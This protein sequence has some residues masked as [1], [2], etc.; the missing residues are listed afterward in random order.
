MGMPVCCGGP[1][2]SSV[3][4]RGGSVPCFR[5]IGEGAR[6]RPLPGD[7][8]T[9]SDDEA[10]GDGDGAVHASDRGEASLEG[11][12]TAPNYDGEVAS[13]DVELLGG[14]VGPTSE[15]DPAGDPVVVEGGSRVHLVSRTAHLEVTRAQFAARLARL[16]RLARLARL[17]DRRHRPR[18]S[19]TRERPTE[20]RSVPCRRSAR[21]SGSG[22]ARSDRPSRSV[23]PR[24]GPC[25]CALSHW[26]MPARW[27]ART[28]SRS[29][30]FRG[31]SS[32]LAPRPAPARPHPAPPGP[33]PMRRTEADAGDR[34]GTPHLPGWTLRRT[35]TDA[36]D[37]LGTP[38]P[39]CHR[40]ELLAARFSR[41]A[42]RPALGSATVE[43]VFAGG[44]PS[45]AERAGPAAEPPEV[46]QPSVSTAPRPAP[47][48]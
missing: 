10:A 20:V 16:V 25:S 17:A 41:S 37:R 5:G 36:G 24:R 47:G 8:D 38:H 35:E 28:G 19:Q 34:L 2:A 26:S 7:S 18:G 43:A 30:C 1:P 9:P 46:R 12:L 32:R 42:G 14:I 23:G 6:S 45:G 27:R 29:K 4:R 21:W 31:S 48:P 22:T 39:G 3:D 44:H 11:Q 33:G 15:T 13:Q 40:P